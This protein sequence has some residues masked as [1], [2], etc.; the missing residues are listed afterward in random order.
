LQGLERV[1]HLP[2]N[3]IVEITP[4][5]NYDS[6]LA[7]KAEE[8]GVPYTV[9]KEF[10]FPA[11]IRVDG[12]VIMQWNI[13]FAND[14]ET[15]KSKNLLFIAGAK[16]GGGGEIFIGD[17]HEEHR[18]M[19][20]QQFLDYLNG[21]VDKGFMTN[22]QATSSIV[23]AV[24]YT[25]SNPQIYSQ[26]VGRHEFMKNIKGS[27]Y[28]LRKYK[29]KTSNIREHFNRL[30]TDFSEGT[31]PYGLGDTRIMLFEPDEI[32]LKID[33]KNVPLKVF[34]GAYA[35]D[36][37][38]MS[39]GDF[40]RNLA[41]TIGRKPSMQ[42]NKLYETK[43]VIRHLSDD[44][45]DYLGLKM[46]QMT[47]YEGM[48]F[49]KDGE[50]F[51]EV[52]VRRG[53]TVFVDNNNVE[54]HH[55][56]STEEA[57]VIAGKYDRD[58]AH[59]GLSDEDGFYKLH[60]LDEKHIKVLFVPSEFSKKKSAY[61]IAEGELTLDPALVDNPDY[62]K[63]IDALTNHYKDVGK[64]YLNTLFQM[65]SDPKMLR[66][67]IY[68]E[69]MSGEMPTEIQEHLD[70]FGE[71]GEGIHLPYLISIIL[72]IL[73]NRFI[74]NGLYKV[75]QRG[76]DGAGGLSTMLVLK[77]IADLTVGKNGFGVSANNQ[78]VFNRL[79][80]L[81]LEDAETRIMGLVAGDDV[82]SVEA[83]V[84]AWYNLPRDERIGMMNNFL[85][86]KPMY[87]K[88]SRQPVTGP[89]VTIMRRIS[90]IVD[91]Y[92]ADVAF[93]TPEDVAIIQGDFD[94]DKIGVEMFDNK[95]IENA[96]VAWQKTDAYKNRAKTAYIS[97]FKLVKKKTI[98]TDYSDFLKSMEDLSVAANSQGLVTN[99]KVIGNILAYK[100]VKIRLKD[101]KGKLSEDVYFEA[102]TPSELVTMDYAPLDKESLMENDFELLK[103]LEAQGDEVVAFAG[104]LYREKITSDNIGD[105][106]AKSSLY[107]RTTHEHE[108]TNLLQMAVDDVKIPL[109]SKIGYSS[110]FMLERMFKRVGDG[111]P[112]G[113]FAP[114]GI[115]HA[116]AQLRQVFN[117]S[118]VRRGLV[119]GV[120]ATIQQNIGM[121]R[122]INNFINAKNIVKT[123]MIK[124]ELNA[125]SKKGH[126]KFLWWYE[127]FEVTSVTMN[128]RI[129]PVEE[130]LSLLAK[131]IMTRVDESTD[132]QF[133]SEWG[134]APGV[135][136]Y[137]V[138]KTAHVNAMKE[139][140]SRWSD[141]AS[142]NNVTEQEMAKGVALMKKISKDFFKIYSDV[143]K[144]TP[145]KVVRLKP[146][147]NEPLRNLIDDYIDD[148]NKLSDNSQM[149]ATL[150][151]LAGTPTRDKS[152]KPVKRVNVMK[153]LP[154]SLMHKPMVKSFAKVWWNMMTKS[155][156]SKFKQPKDTRG[157]M[158]KGLKFGE[159]V[160][161]SKKIADRFCG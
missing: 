66:K 126:P 12:G 88:L 103:L 27:N 33:G 91:G 36:G 5:D 19:T 37:W 25:E 138:Y 8:E 76:E 42:G 16:G 34:A 56:G 108:M 9:E 130:L 139:M 24:R 95:Q 154:I 40:F 45:V 142:I 15:G 23:G 105:V 116:L 22:A 13:E 32:T 161:L 90:K 59:G 53:T 145:G 58:K 157:E 114:K 97:I 1:I 107:L 85:K 147:Y 69:I 115:N 100:E 67:E 63:F 6:D 31:T 48:E 62:I 46:M 109:L 113:Q 158:Y 75:R 136:S 128:D 84:A 82:E 129:A 17:V 61:P 125:R 72:P 77:P 57:K 149:Y 148:W 155:I 65:H 68:R 14:F 79:Q 73:N 111:G 54:F 156:N 7:K 96:F 83:A 151:F 30:R 87:A 159:A 112:I 29:G 144:S 118:P 123:T 133:N 18:N 92:H 28:L 60:T 146:E 52:K 131:E 11:N 49:F 64:D 106:D 50:K 140:E 41:N 152:G 20:Q 160:E 71:S 38:L 26:I 98:M 39:S 110:R 153:L 99:S 102:K 89:A 101:P 132:S 21:E 94:G 51:A 81:I 3:N 141:I 135:Y 4:N 127:G 104:G 80:K 119:G 121:S 2:L 10:V 44:L 143:K 70:N 55:L 35:F 120:Q 117:Y 122:N 134:G 43:T 78:T 93:L 137:D 47:P 150:Y 86:A 74:N 124:G